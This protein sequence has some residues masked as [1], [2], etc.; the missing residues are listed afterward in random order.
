MKF[1]CP[2]CERLVEL[3][4]F[5]VEGA[6]LVLTCP[7][8]GNAAKVPNA[9][10]A[11]E[12]PPLQLASISGA[13]NVVTLRS[14]GTD[15]IT[16]AADAANRGAFEVPAG[17]CPKCVALRQ[18]SAV[19]CFQCGLTFAQFDP[20]QVAVP[21]WLQQAWVSLLGDWGNETLHTELRQRA[22]NELELA[23]VGRLYR[24]R[25]A[26][27]PEDPFALRGRDEVLR[28]AVVPSALLANEKSVLTEKVS[29]RWKIAIVGFSLLFALAVLGFMARAM[30]STE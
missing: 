7:A 1:L 25:L 30:L 12:R 21:P 28:M 10:A 19:S 24:L 15:A 27:N 26:S 3:R 5:Q 8:C 4:D 9:A 13:S 16:A 22:M 17:R 29:P 23:A 11:V 14:A 18:P 2:K 20:T 6:T